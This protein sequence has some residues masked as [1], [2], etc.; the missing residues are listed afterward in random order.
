MAAALLEPRPLVSVILR[1]THVQ[2][3]KYASGLKDDQDGQSNQR[4]EP[5]R[6]IGRSP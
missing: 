4:D 6:L 5:L 3:Q 2:E 1:C